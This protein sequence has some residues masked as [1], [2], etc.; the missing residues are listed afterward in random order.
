MATS[1]F[2]L[3][4]LSSRGLTTPPLSLSHALYT[5]AQFTRYWIVSNCKM[6]SQDKNCELFSLQFVSWLPFYDQKS[7]VPLFS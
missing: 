3:L 1:A 5:A 6:G 4:E 2:G 7:S